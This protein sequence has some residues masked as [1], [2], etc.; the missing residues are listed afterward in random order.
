MAFEEKAF[1]VAL[2]ITMADN[3]IIL[4]GGAFMMEVTTD[5]AGA[6]IDVK[7]DLSAVLIATIKAIMINPLI[8]SVLLAIIFLTAKLSLPSPLA[9]FAGQMTNA[10]GPLALVALGCALASMADQKYVRSDAIMLAVLK[11]I[12]LPVMVYFSC[13]YLFDLNDFDTKVAVLMAALPVAVNVFILASRYKT[14]ELAIAGSMM[15][16][17]LSGVI[18]ISFLMMIDF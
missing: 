10:T 13:Q 18:V 9:V 16:S 14:Y 1:L 11:T 15:L 4:A 12:V 5:N 7:R 2:M 17:T 3:L 6:N 8:V